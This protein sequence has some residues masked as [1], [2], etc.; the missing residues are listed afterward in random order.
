[1]SYANMKYKQI[2]GPESLLVGEGLCSVHVRQHVSTSVSN[3]FRTFPLADIWNRA[4]LIGQF[5]IGHM[6]CNGYLN[7]RGRWK[8]DYCDKD[9][10]AFR[11]F[12]VAL[13]VF[14]HLPVPGSPLKHLLTIPCARVSH[15]IFGQSRRPV[16]TGCPGWQHVPHSNSQGSFG[17]KSIVLRCLRGLWKDK[18]QCVSRI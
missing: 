16:Y 15:V 9:F 6:R 8:S 18:L 13:S 4:S 5:L 2:F 14:F 12:G 10:F 7:I 1:M 3:T 17:H 11:V